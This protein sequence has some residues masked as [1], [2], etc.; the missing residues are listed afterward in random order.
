MSALYEFAYLVI[1]SILPFALGALVLYVISD[2]KDKNFFELAVKTFRNGELLVF[3][4]SMLAPILYLTLHDPEQ[5]DP[6][7]HK[8]PLSTT[9]SL[10]IVTSAALFA[11]MKSGGVKDTEFVYYF[12]VFLTLCALFFRFLAILYH[13]VRMPALSERELR[14]PQDQF[15]ENFRE[16]V[17]Q[18]L[19]TDQKAFVGAFQDRVEEEP[20]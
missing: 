13:K 8:L 19:R 18:E 17:E 11:V 14:G 15:V 1:W 12:S 2:A 10:I 9:V 5:A 3:T 6:F 16:R 7:P 20:T 4:I